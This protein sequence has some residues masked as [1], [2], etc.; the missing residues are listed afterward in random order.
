MLKWSTSAIRNC[1]V[2]PAFRTD[3]PKD[4]PEEPCSVSA[5]VR[6]SGRSAGD[7]AV[8]AAELTA[9]ESAEQPAAGKDSIP[10]QA[11]GISAQQRETDR[12]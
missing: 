12:D 2:K 11:A 1:V 5:A 9:A 3:T 7:F 4:G 6:D 10:V 8:H